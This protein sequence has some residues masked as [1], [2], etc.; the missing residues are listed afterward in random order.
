MKAVISKEE[1]LSLIGKV[2]SIVA[3]KPAIPALSNVLIEAIDDQIIVS[4]TD[5]TVSM[6][7]F[8][9]GKVIEE[10]SSAI[11]AKKFFQLMREI[12]SSQVKISTSSNGITEVIAG[13]SIFKI[14]SLSKEEF[15][16]LPDL[17]SATQIHIN[18]STLK[19]LLYRC[20]FS[21]AR[22]D[23]KYVLNG[24]HLNILDQKMTFL[25]T[26]G[27]R[28]AKVIADV[29]TDPSFQG[30][31]IIPL[32]AVEEIIR[33]L[34]GA[35][36]D[37]CLSLMHDKISLE[38]DQYTLITKLLSGQY[39]DVEKVIPQNPK[40]NIR[41][42]REELMILLRQV[43]LFIPESSSPARFVFEE[44]Q[45]TLMAVSSE[46]GEG[47]A[48]MPVDYSGQ[49]IEIAFNPYYFLD[50]LKHSRDETIQFSIDDLFNP[51]KITDSTSA[52]FV[53]MPMRIEQKPAN[54][55]KID[56]SKSPAYT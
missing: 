1:I 29:K 46:I 54:E 42:H 34:D 21:A 16:P 27:K 33:I 32:K 44:G 45:L 35:S 3:S 15:P 12:T 51:G 14:H 52:I 39:P 6:R 48:V 31:Y 24:I 26:D 20:C 55:E 37:V 49:K 43:S 9:D 36:N 22:E 30:S 38:K 5:L 7:C 23:S 17:S 41:I 4:V 19:E 53:I 56:V 25:G 10:G 40:I 47:K 11:P 18:G 2:Q 8:I 13:S 28:L 50:I